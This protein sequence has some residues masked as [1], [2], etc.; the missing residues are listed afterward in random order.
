MINQQHFDVFLAHHSQD[1]PQVKAI[2]TELK[3][4]GLNPWLDEEQIQPGRSFQDVL[5]QAISSSKS[6]AIFIGPGGLGRWQKWEMQAFINK[7]V[8]VDVPIIPV[9]LP[10]VDKCPEDLHFL[11]ELNWVRFAHTIDDVKALNDLVWGITGKRPQH[12]NSDDNSDREDSEPFS[13]KDRF[14]PLI[15]TVIGTVLSSFITLAIIHFS[16]TQKFP[17]NL[18]TQICFDDK[19]NL[20]NTDSNSN[21]KDGIQAFAKSDF[22]SAIKK[23]DLSR[24][25]NPSDPEALIYLNNAKAARDGIRQ[26]IKIAV[27]V[28]I[29]NNQNIAQEILRGVAQAQNEVNQNSE[30][31]QK[32]LQVMIVNDN[33]EPKLAAKI[34]NELVEDATILA[35]V[36]HNSSEASKA[37]APIY[38]QEGLVMITPTS[39]ADSLR[40]YGSP[41]FHTM[42]KIRDTAKQLTNYAIKT[43]HKNNI[44]ICFDSKA[45]ASKT[46]KAEF[47]DAIKEAGG[48][49]NST[50]CDF[51]TPTFK[52]STIWSDAI[53]NTA[54]SI[55]LLPG[56]NTI[57]KAI[58]IAQANRGRLTLFSSPTGNTYQTLKQGR[59]DVNEMVVA[60]PWNPAIGKGK[61]FADSAKKLWGGSVNW[62]TAMAYDATLAIITGLKQGGD[63]RDEFKKALSSKS[64]LFDGA[65]GEVHFQGDRETP[66]SLL[67]V[68]SSDVND[69]GYD[70]VPFQP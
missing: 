7:C 33:N 25:M 22:S 31:G 28:P 47:E 68:Q 39:D 44:V 27:S 50:D 11:K 60:V 21:K 4:R 32:L 53:N 63:T 43:A 24:Q 41:I 26:T 52:P 62:R 59:C 38:A 42:P 19:D 3:Q 48:K 34:A 46:L 55:L 70:F 16:Q 1:K 2:A 5:Q 49:I 12:D 56:V 20:V 10:G 8:E 58:Q 40:E 23:L 18:G 67:K 54:D 15:G 29:G 36:G 30:I 6:A 14:R 45:T 13:K 37:A 35:V 65:T 17:V 9:M 57:D 69:T 51:S 66:V 61:S 64:F